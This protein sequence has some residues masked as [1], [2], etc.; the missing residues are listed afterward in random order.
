MY[1]QEWNALV[2]LWLLILIAI[3]HRISCGI[4]VYSTGNPVEYGFCV[5]PSL[6]KLAFDSMAS[7]DT[8]GRIFLCFDIVLLYKIKKHLIG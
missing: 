3:F 2:D 8:C 7:H 5:G 6:Y 1:V 4:Y